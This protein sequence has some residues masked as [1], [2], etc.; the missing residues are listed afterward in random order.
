MLKRQSNNLCGVGAHHQ[1]G[2]AE[3]SIGTITRWAMCMLLYSAL[4]WPRATDTIL[5]PLA[6]TYV[7]WIWN[8]LPNI[9]SWYSPEEL[10]SRSKS[11]HV[12]LN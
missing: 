8:R 9:D 7:V 10:F 4:Y 1:N 3:R 2:V 11:T 6:I 12:E 5:W